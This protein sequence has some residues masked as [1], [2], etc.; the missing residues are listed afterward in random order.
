[1]DWYKIRGDDD[2]EWNETKEEQSLKTVITM[3][4]SQVSAYALF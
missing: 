1:M 4:T 2:D 3:Y